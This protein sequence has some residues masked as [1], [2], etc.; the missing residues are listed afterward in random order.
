MA[1]PLR[2]ALFFYSLMDYQDASPLRNAGEYTTQCIIRNY[3]H[4][5]F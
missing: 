3:L 1:S 5:H 4:R 2:N